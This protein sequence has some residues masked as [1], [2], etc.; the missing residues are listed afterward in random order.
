MLAIHLCSVK[1]YFQMS[2]GGVLVSIVIR[3]EAEV[4]VAKVIVVPGVPM[5]ARIE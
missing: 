1:L 4:M 5:V 2:D 3:P